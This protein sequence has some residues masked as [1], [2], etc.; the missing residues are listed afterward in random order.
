M[1]IVIIIALIFG[2]LMHV[3]SSNAKLSDIG[4]IIFACALLALFFGA[5]P[6]VPRLR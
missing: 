3:L 2:L 6:H 1:E 5:S 4:R